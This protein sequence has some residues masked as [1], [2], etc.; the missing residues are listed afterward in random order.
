M[1]K[2]CRPSEVLAHVIHTHEVQAQEV[3]VHE[4]LAQ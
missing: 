3:Q 2:K 4:V 1:V